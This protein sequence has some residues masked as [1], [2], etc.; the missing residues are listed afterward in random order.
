[1]AENNM[2]LLAEF[3]LARIQAIRSLIGLKPEDVEVQRILTE[4]FGV[5][6][7]MPYCSIIDWAGGIGD[8]VGLIVKNSRIEAVKTSTNSDTQ[9]YIRFLENRVKELKA[10]VNCGIE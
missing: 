8:A 3:K 6:Q 4:F 5:P 1:M 9:A 7:T 10:K 2:T